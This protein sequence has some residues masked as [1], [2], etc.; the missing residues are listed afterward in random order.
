MQVYMPTYYDIIIGNYLTGNFCSRN[1]PWFYMPWTN[2][3]MC[4]TTQLQNI[5]SKSAS[6]SQLQISHFEHALAWIFGFQDHIAPYALT[7]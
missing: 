6:T 2:S 5:S 4:M 1:K 3:V 7:K